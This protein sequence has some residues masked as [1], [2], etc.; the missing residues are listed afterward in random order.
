M[1]SFQ[2]RKAAELRR[3]FDPQAAGPRANSCTARIERAHK[4]PTTSMYNPTHS[5]DSISACT[6]RSLSLRSASVCISVSVRRSVASPY[7]MRRRPTTRTPARSS[8]AAPT[9]AGSSSRSCSCRCSIGSPS[10][11]LAA[12]RPRKAKVFKLTHLTLLHARLFLYTELD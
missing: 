11:A 12:A 6:K 5:S 3:G 7:S 1:Y 4:A 9:R 2:V 8:G 10:L